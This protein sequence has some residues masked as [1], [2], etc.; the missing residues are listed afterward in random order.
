MGGC[1]MGRTSAP[2]FLV[3]DPFTSG[4]A[5]APALVYDEM[6]TDEIDVVVAASVVAETEDF[7]ECKLQ[8][9]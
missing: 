3:T 8:K 6:K 4:A 1:V 7:I 9:N 5:G 2:A